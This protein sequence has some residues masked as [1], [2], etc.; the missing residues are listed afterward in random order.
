MPKAPAR[1]PSR[2]HE[3]KGPDSLAQ[4]AD[5]AG[6]DPAGIAEEAGPE[7]LCA[8]TRTAHPVEE[9]IRFVAAPDGTIV[10]DLA[11]KLPGR[12]VWI[13]CDRETLAQAAK[14]GGPFAKSLKRAV[15][16]PANLVEI[17]EQ[18][19]A[20]RAV[21]ALSMARKAGLVATGYAQVEAAIAAGD[22]AVL[23]H[24]SD[25][26]EGGR[27]KLDR[28]YAAVCRSN[29][30]EPRILSVL[31]IEQMSLAIGRA[32]VVHAALK[33]GGATEKFSSEAG[34][35]MRYRSGSG[36][37]HHGTLPPNQE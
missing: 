17:V 28:I 5:E 32:N 36:S 29:G 12:G 8:V 11:S 2:G 1:R 31:T 26:A 14:G 35:L 27:E 21:G 15:K 34:R 10:A 16:L 4:P 3:A 23:I 37:C 24:G 7:R 22:T 25:A 18:G 33:Q 19:L 30:Q 13:S 9:L 20:G 6:I